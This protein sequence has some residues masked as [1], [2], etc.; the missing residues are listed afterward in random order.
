MIKPN[1][2]RRFTLWVIDS[3]RSVMDVRYNPLKYVPDPSLQ[4]YFTLVLFT[5]WSVYF[6]FVATFYLGWYGYSIIASIFVHLAI[7]V[8][9]VITN[10]IFMDAERNGHKWLSEW[11]EE[12]SNYKL[13]LSRATN[14]VRILWDIDKEA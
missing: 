14:G 6:G 12:Q 11:R 5:I 7:L 9:I 2:F 8:P 10:G 13:F 3:W 4:A 1:L